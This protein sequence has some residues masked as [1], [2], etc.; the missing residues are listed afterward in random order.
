[1]HETSPDIE[2]HWHRTLDSTQSKSISVEK[3]IAI[4]NTIM[5]NRSNPRHLRGQTKESRNR[6]F[7]N[8]KEVYDSS[9][10]VIRAKPSPS[11]LISLQ[12]DTSK[13]YTLRKFKE[14]RISNSHTKMMTTQDVTEVSNFKTSLMS[15]PP[16]I[17]PNKM[18]RSLAVKSTL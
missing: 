16:I 7:F 2:K 17:K 5:R 1:M 9:L 18:A 11:A 6:N 14:I 8:K 10:P 15:K 13:M 12:S 4:R 3:K